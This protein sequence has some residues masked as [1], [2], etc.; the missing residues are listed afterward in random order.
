[1]H[2]E[3]TRAPG[4][5]GSKPRRQRTPSK[6]F[7]LALESKDPDS[8]DAWQ[9]DKAQRNRLPKVETRVS[10]ADAN[11]SIK[12]NKKDVTLAAQSVTYEQLQELT[13]LPL[14]QAAD[15]VG[16][17]PNIIYTCIYIQRLRSD[18][19]TYLCLNSLEGLCLKR[20][21]E[22][23]ALR[24]GLKTTQNWYTPYVVHTACAVCRRHVVR[25]FCAHWL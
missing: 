7:T 24:A 22:A 1:M 19:L 16:V 11:G 5:S 10:L 25:L 4:F 21:A 13:H 15:T 12:R 8:A 14:R 9:N 2:A 20:F 6:K 3:D 17:R 23:T 18:S